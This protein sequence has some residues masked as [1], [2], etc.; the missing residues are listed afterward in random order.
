[1]CGGSERGST[2]VTLSL[3][4]LCNQQSR[5]QVA[6]CHAATRSHVNA[7]IASPRNVCTRVNAL[8]ETSVVVATSNCQDRW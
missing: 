7:G 3:A 4:G 6:G 2:A 1:M 8:G 5:P